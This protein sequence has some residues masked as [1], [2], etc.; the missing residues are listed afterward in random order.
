MSEHEFCFSDPTHLC[1][2]NVFVDYLKKRMLFA[3]YPVCFMLPL[4][5]G[6]SL[7]WSLQE[8]MFVYSL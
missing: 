6:V 5:E 1:L 2:G 4:P 3:S 8:T 7:A